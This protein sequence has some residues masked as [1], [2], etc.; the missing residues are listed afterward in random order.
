M[1]VMF[2][3]NGRAALDCK[4]EIIESYVKLI[5]K[6]KVF[7]VDTAVATINLFADCS[8]TGLNVVVFAHAFCFIIKLFFNYAQLSL[9]FHEF[10]FIWVR[11]GFNGQSSLQ[12]LIHQ[13]S[14]TC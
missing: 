9:N 14:L 8:F 7:V 12:H 4:W 2:T 6:L 3:D 1:C 10:P 5:I 11:F 13:C